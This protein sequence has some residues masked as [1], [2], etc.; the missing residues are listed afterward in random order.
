MTSIRRRN[1]R[2][3][4]EVNQLT[5]QKLGV[6]LVIILVFT[7]ITGFVAV[8]A[9]LAYV[10]LF[11]DAVRESE[12]TKWMMTSIIGPIASVIVLFL[13]SELIFK[14]RMWINVLFRKN[15]GS[16]QAEYE[17]IG[18]YDKN[19][20]T[21]KIMDGVVEVKSG[22]LLLVLDK[23]HGT[24]VWQWLSPI[25]LNRDHTIILEI[26]DLKGRTWSVSTRPIISCE[27]W[28]FP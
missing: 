5:F 17:I 21:Y 7:F 28:C 12:Q 18:D 3:A 19:A 2:T 23:S 1:G 25:P 15:S 16:S 22:Q 20:S 27:A 10:G 6:A 26:V 11:G 8:V 4:G 13:K 9:V 24:F 14:D